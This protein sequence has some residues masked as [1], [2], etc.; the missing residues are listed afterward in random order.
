MNKVYSNLS[1]IQIELLKLYKNNIP[2]K[3]L[4]DIKLMLSNYFAQKASDAMD[5]FAK[6]KNISEQ[7][8]INWANEHNRAKTG[9]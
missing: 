1:N 2:D 7:D 4:F 8:Y 5:S 3:Y 9:N 6:E